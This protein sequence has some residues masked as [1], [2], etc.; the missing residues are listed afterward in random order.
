MHAF[1]QVNL[2]TVQ[3]EH[4]IKCYITSLQGKLRNTIRLQG[5]Q[6]LQTRWHLNR[7]ELVK[8][9]T[10]IGSENNQTYLFHCLFEGLQAIKVSAHY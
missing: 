3:N 1:S 10:G 8:D 6:T 7:G 2:G 9:T 5:M 4:I